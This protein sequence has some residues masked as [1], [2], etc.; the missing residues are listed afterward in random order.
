MCLCVGIFYCPILQERQDNYM[1]NNNKKTAKS[2][3]RRRLKCRVRAVTHENKGFSLVEL[4]VVI[5][6]MAILAGAVSVALIKYI[7]KSRDSVALTNAGNFKMTVELSLTEASEGKLG[8]QAESDAT[9]FSVQ[10]LSS[11]AAEPDKSDALIYDIYNTFNP[12]GSNFEAIA[13]VDAGAVVQITYKDLKSKKVYVFYTDSSKKYGTKV[14]S[15][16]AGEWLTYKTNDGDAWVQWYS[17]YEG[18]YT[19]QWWNGH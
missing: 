15:G 12:G 14:E 10:Y 6:I 17:I 13:I 18:T 5:A 1:M 8:S 2:L 19:T 16:K 7:Q 9:S 3:R 4:I 11:T